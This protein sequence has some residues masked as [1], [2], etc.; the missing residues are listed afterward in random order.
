M[1]ICMLRDDKLARSVTDIQQMLQSN[2]MQEER[3]H[4]G[5]FIDRFEISRGGV[6]RKS[7]ICLCQ[8][9]LNCARYQ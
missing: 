3:K 6:F 7:V 9:L 1:D 4:S 5:L 8:R 2:T